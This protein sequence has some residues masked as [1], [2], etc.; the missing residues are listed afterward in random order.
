MFKS[1]SIPIGTI[2]IYIGIKLPLFAD[3]RYL[4]I[5]YIVITVFVKQNPKF[6]DMER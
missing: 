6:I 4:C 3:G 2:S 5:V 1:F